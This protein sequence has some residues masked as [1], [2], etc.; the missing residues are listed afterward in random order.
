[1][2]VRAKTRNSCLTY[3]PDDVVTWDWRGL[4]LIGFGPGESNHDPGLY[5]L[6]G[7]YAVDIADDHR[8]V[9]RAHGAERDLCAELS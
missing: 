6:T 2:R 3:R 5:L 4:V 1:M 8:W 7:E 9:R